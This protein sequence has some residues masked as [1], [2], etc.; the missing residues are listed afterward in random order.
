MT[1]CSLGTELS[2]VGRQLQPPQF[3]RE[4]SRAALHSWGRARA[5]GT[6]T[7]PEEVFLTGERT[8]GFLLMTSDLKLVHANAEALRILLYPHSP[9]SAQDFKGSL[10]AKIRSI[11]LANGVGAPPPLPTEFISGQRRYICR[12]FSLHSDANNEPGHPALAMIFER[13]SHTAFDTSQVAAQF[14]LTPREQETLRFL[15]MGLTNKEI[16]HRMNISP[17]TVK[18]FLKLIMMKMG[19]STRSGILGKTIDR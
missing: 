13:T 3:T 4:P 11:L 5:R 7:V 10:A 17:N 12:T 16:G 9:E 2:N 18:A 14:H 1:S 19:V 8:T 15:T 6:F